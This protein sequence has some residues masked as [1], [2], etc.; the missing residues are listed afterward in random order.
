MNFNHL[1]PLTRETLSC[2]FNIIRNL[3]YAGPI[4]KI[5]FLDIINKI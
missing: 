2:L 1:P 4:P 5:V 3:I